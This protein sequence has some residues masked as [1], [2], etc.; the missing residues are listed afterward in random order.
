MSNPTPAAGDEFGYD[1]DIDGGLVVVGAYSDDPGGIS[2]AG[3]AYVFDATTGALVSTLSNP[4]PVATDSFGWSVGISGNLVVVGA[5]GDDTGASSAGIV[6]VFNATTGVLV[7]TLNNPSPTAFDGFGWSVDISG[8]L[9][10]VG[11]Y[12]DDPGGVSNTGAAYVFD[13]NT[14]ALVSTLS[15]PNPAAA[16]NFGYVV[17]IS[18]TRALVASRFDDPGGLSSAG[19]AYVFDANTGVLI[20]ELIDPDRAADNYFGD[21]IDLDGDIAAVGAPG[22]D[23]PGGQG[24]VYLF[25]VTDGSVLHTITSPVPADEYIGN[26]VSLSDGR[27]LVGSVWTDM[28]G[29]VW[30]VG[31]AYLYD[32]STGG[33]IS[34]I[35]N[36]DPSGNEFFGL[37]SALSGDVAALSVYRD[38]G[39]IGVAYLFAPGT[40]G[41]CTNPVGVVGDILYN[42]TS[43][44][45]QYCDGSGWIGSGP[46]GDGGGGCTDPV[47]DAGDIVYNSSHNYLQYCEGDDWI[48]IGRK[49]VSEIPP[50]GCPVIGNTCSDGSIYAGLT[51]D[52]NAP[53][54]AAASNAPTQMNWDNG[55][56]NNID[57]TIVNCTSGVQ[58]AC[59]TGEAN[60]TFLAGLVNAAAPYAA[61]TYCQDLVAHGRSDWYLPALNELQ[62]IYT[63]LYLGGFGGLTNHDYW[64][65]SEQSDDSGKNIYFGDGNTY[66]GGKSNDFRVRC[67]RK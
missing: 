5:Y 63:N 55:L 2:N 15:N 62:L 34:T 20:R 67:V 1:V 39:S 23:L 60:T 31:R 22:H 28:P 18:G 46:V 32:I 21:S 56:G 38:S 61:A 24:A 51:P 52:G 8:S 42:T 50:T 33:M 25:D 29:G 57:T 19:A 37:P 26:S 3:S 58:T 64:S 11:A 30:Y 6:Y 4:S 47:G 43:H 17:A 13:A 16:D 12:A 66:N 36:P 44:V 49:D 54:Y 45:L 27:V 40:G 14:G 7:S 65:S 53:M 9:A 35:D 59:D 41:G 10:V 48:G